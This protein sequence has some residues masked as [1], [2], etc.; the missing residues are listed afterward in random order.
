MQQD[1]LGLTAKKEVDIASWYEQVVLKSEIAD[2]GEVKGTIVIRPKGY[3]IWEQL[4]KEFN[5]FLEQ[6]DVENCSF[7]LLIPE[8]FFKLEA[9]HATGFAPE[10]AWVESSARTEKEE[11]AIIRPTSETIIVD[12]FRKWLRTYKQL[13]IKVNQWCNILRWETKQTK[14][15]LR[16]RE[17]HW[18]EGHCIYR[19]EKSCMDDV[20]KVIE[21]YQDVAKRVFALPTF[22][23]RKSITERFAGAQ[24]TWAIESIMPDTKSLQMGTSHYL[25]QGF[26]KVFGVSYKEDNE[27][28]ALPHYNSWGISTR[29][30]GAMIMTHSDNKGLVLPPK[31]VKRKIVIIP[32]IKKEQPVGF[33]S[34]VNQVHTRT[35]VYGSWIDSRLD[36]S[37]G[38]KLN[39]WEL[40]G[41]PLM[42]IIGGQEMQQGK[43]TIKFRDQEKVTVPLSELENLD[44]LFTQMHTRLYDKAHAF[45]QSR[46]KHAQTLDEFEKLI[47]E[48]YMV[49]APFFDDAASEKKI[50]A[51]YGVGT[52]FLFDCEETA[53]L[54]S[55][56]M[57]KT[58]AYFSRSY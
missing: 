37:L 7:P 42:I 47:K 28:D 48:G 1:A 30:I 12:S 54:F 35:Q 36:Y 15:F 23:G 20:T 26:M 38:W 22:I 3:Y 41:V 9:T 45:M 21:E 27:Q 19:D 31:C 6:I 24:D 18:Q 46:M 58:R 14:L 39:E 8:R 10:L 53:C 50:D 34:Y 2:F 25:G 5:Q 49:S 29:M 16:G 11:K 43:V 51:T 40:K 32:V 52:R 55:G 4:Q 44:S 33:E 56:K 13:P 17:F 57:T